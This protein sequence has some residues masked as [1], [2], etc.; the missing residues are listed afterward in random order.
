[1][2]SNV[3]TQESSKSVG[4]TSIKGDKSKFTS[5]LNQFFRPEFLNRLDEVIIF[6]PLDETIV[7]KILDLEMTAIH[8]RLRQ[9]GYTL[10]LTNEARSFILK[11]GFDPV[12]G[13]RPLR[14]AIER[15]ITRP[16]SASIVEDSF[17]DKSIIHAFAADDGEGLRFEAEA[18]EVT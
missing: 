17:E 11:K 15:Y 7:S 2:T 9:Q 13:A 14:R 3:G 8:E 10:T 6:N 18:D 5:H 16:L 4:F 12:N 1:M